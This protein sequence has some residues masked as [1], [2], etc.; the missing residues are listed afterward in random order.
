MLRPRLILCCRSSLPGKVPRAAEQLVVPANEGKLRP[1]SA[2]A[3]DKVAPPALQ[4]VVQGL[5]ARRDLLPGRY[6]LWL[7]PLSR[8]RDCVR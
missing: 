1:G 5:P 8:D 7:R 4:P 3:G 6:R 2:G